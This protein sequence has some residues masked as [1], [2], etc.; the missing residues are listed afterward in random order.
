MA[1]DREFPQWC[2]PSLIRCAEWRVAWVSADQR[3]DPM[4]KG[5]ATLRTWA[6]AVGLGVVGT[7]GFAGTADWTRIGEKD[8]ITSYLRPVEGER[9]EATRGVTTVNVPLCE[10][11]SFYVDPSLAT[12]WV[13][14]LTEYEVIELNA[15]QSIVWQRFD[16]PWPVAD[17]EFLLQVNVTRPDERTV[18]VSLVSTTDPR[19]PPPTDGDGLVRGVMSPSSWT[20]TRLSESRTKVDMVGH[21]DPSGAFPAWLINIIQQTFPYNTLSAFAREAENGKV[22]L[23]SECADW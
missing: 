1:A 5:L 18:K 23:R 22:P 7:V 14:M 19:F 9:V 10:L 20:F 3:E 15:R 2:G 4:M 16:M 17:R 21:A 12:T 11:I 13:D 6:G 8:G